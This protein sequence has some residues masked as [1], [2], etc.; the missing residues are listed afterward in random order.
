MP[1][2][3]PN[4]SHPF[5]HH[6]H[7]IGHVPALPA[8]ATNRLLGFTASSLVGGFLAIFLYEFFGFSIQ[9][10]LLWYAINFALKLPFHVVAA[11]IFSRIGLVISMIIGTLGLMVFYWVFFLLDSGSAINPYVLMGTGMIGLMI[12]SGFYWSPFNIDFAEFTD[13]KKRGSQVGVFYAAQRLI[14][15]I[16]PIVAGYIIMTYGHQLNF[17]VG[18]I[19]AGTSIVPLIF[20]PRFDVEYEFGFFESFQKLFSKKFRGM[21]I[22][23]M[24]LGAENIVGFTVWPIF[25]YTLFE[26]DYLNVGLFTSVIVIIGLALE[27]FVGKQAD[28]RSVKKMLKLGTGIY[29]LG[30]V[31]KGLVET[32]VG[33]FAASTFHSFGSIML[34]TPMD[35][36]MYEQAADSGHYVDEYT[37]L[38][39][40]SLSAGRVVMLLLLVGLTSVFSLGSAFFLAA[41]VTLGINRLAK[42][43]A[44]E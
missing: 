10:V 15:V 33:V 20:L 9:L 32:V 34:R 21:S 30:W 23:M 31:G 35:T 4:Q 25:L 13:K 37:V 11:K 19:I 14:G 42:Y 41:L 28:K 22:S 16:A 1:K 8:L 36:M 5:R 40:M 43:Q 12:V 39:E 38:R 6:R 26:G 29:A 3:H 44:G 24:S 2:T 18:M 27:L 7:S 17:F